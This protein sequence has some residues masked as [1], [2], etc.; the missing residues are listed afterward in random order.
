[1][2]QERNNGLFKPWPLGSCRINSCGYKVIK[3]SNTG[4][5]WMPYQ[6]YLWEKHYKRKLP[7]GMIIAFLDGNKSNLDIN[8]LVAVTRAESLYLTRHHLRFDDARLSETGTL[9]AKVAVKAKERRKKKMKKVTVNLDNGQT[10]CFHDCALDKFQKSL[11]ENQVGQFLV[12]GDA[13]INLDHVLT[14]VEAEDDNENK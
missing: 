1:M 4:K 7:K 2:V 11:E 8:N 5:K 12:T 9:I 14:I 3:V 6:R 10:A 13:M